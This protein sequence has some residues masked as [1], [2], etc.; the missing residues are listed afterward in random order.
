MDKY[1]MHP[2]ANDS[3]LKPTTAAIVESPNLPHIT[4]A[5]IA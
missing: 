4:G 2:Q 5:V 3:I 1:P